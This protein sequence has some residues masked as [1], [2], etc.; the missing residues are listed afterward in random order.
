MAYEYWGYWDINNDGIV[1]PFVATWV[2]DVMIRLE[3]NPYPDK[4]L[5]Y[6][7]VQ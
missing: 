1:K 5:P 2:G 3:E 4:Q 6:V 7:L